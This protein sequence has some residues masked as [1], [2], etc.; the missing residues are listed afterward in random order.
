MQSIDY[1][2]DID[3]MAGF[4][5]QDK[6]RNA[7]MLNGSF[8]DEGYDWWWHSFTGENAQTGEEKSFFIEFFTIN[9]ELGGKEPVFGQAERNRLL[10]VKPS[11]LMIKA[12]CWG[13]DACQL[14]R[15]FGWNDVKITKTVPFE[16]EAGDCL[17]NEYELRGSVDVSDG[18]VIDHPEWMCD[19]GSMSFDLNVR[20]IIPFN[21]GYGAG[22]ALRSAKA[23]EMYWHAE[24]MKTMYSGSVILNGVKYIVKPETSY[25]YADKN[26]GESFTSPWV[27]L[28]SNDLTSRKSNKKLLNSAFDIGGGRPVVF[29]KALDRKLLGAFYYEGTEYEFNFSKAWEGTHTKFTSKETEDEVLWHVRQES[30]TALMDVKVRCSKDEMLLVNYEAPDGSKKHN[31][32][33]NGGTGTGIVK[34]YEKYPGGLY[35]VDEIVAGH[36]GCEYGEYC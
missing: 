10:G 23:F 31:R 21:V 33:W 24:G 12:G 16:I 18:D 14:H 20:K 2:K 11:Y 9:P 27:W 32:L 4:S 6:S 29:G 7:F 30:A 26:W 19:A 22:A 35:L 36:V 5:K 28:S 25:G 8:A 17:A 1:W 3:I 34:L 15:F 13:K